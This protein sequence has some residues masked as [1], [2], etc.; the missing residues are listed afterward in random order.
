MNLKDFVTYIYPKTIAFK[1][2]YRGLIPPPR[3]IT[4][5]FSVTNLCQS[6]CKTCNIWRIYPDKHQNISDEL[7]IEEIR[8]IFKSMGRVY[9][10]NISGG[11][12]FLRKD[13]PEIIEAGVDYLRPAIIHIPT[14]ALAPEKII[15]HSQVI[16]EML[17]RKA[18][19][20]VFTIKPSLD[21]VGELHDEI[22]GVKGNWDK[23]LETI[24]RLQDL[25]KR[26][27]NLHIEIGTVVS[28]FN[29]HCLD[30][31]E[32]FVASLG[33]QSY[34]NE[35]AEQ[36]EEFLNIG[37]PI[38]PTGD[39]YAELMKGFAE[40]I[41]KNLKNKRLL[42]QITESLRLVYYELAARIVTEHRQVIPCYAGITNVHLTPH[43][44]L[45][46]CCVLGYAKPM[47][48]LR[49]SNY[50]FWK[51]WHSAEA[52]EVRKSIKNKECACP[53]A[54]QAYS[55]IICHTPSLLK[56]LRN[57]LGVFLKK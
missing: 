18:P 36:R 25:E 29:K 19:H 8:K 14:N 42:A 7:N 43:G 20:T 31:I 40:K 47:G 10:F 45:W 32:E 9:F 56:A 37:D 26:H 1:L 52:K 21:G 4:L 6:R 33:V 5:T 11:E 54:N 27:P 53:L 49:K 2:A 55:N 57:I 12:P 16:L 35:I 3:P 28:N 24:K 22:R 30:E 48:N 13:L 51:I 44:D 50:D 39:E 41:R 23:L 46:P 38:T 15:A 34:R 17:S